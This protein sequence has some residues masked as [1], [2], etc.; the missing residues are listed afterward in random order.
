ML[1]DRQSE[2]NLI[3]SHISPK[4]ALR[5]ADATR[6]I[7]TQGHSQNRRLARLWGCGA[8]RTVQLNIRE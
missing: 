3:H 8:V 6:R 7:R 2:S 4:H 1:V 5:G